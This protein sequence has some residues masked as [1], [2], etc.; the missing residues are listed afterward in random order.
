MDRIEHSQIVREK[1]GL[2]PV[3]QNP[4][5]PE[6]Q[7]ILD[8]FLFG[9]VWQQGGL[10]DVQRELITV[11]VLAAL[12]T[13]DQ[14]RSHVGA[15]LCVG[16]TPVQI[17]E[18]IYQCAPYIGFPRTLV[19]AQQA[20]Q[21]FEQRGISLPHPA[22][23]TVTEETR[24]QK[25]LEA[26]CAIFGQET[27]M[28]MRGSAPEDLK[29]IQDYLSAY[30]FGDIY[31][32]GGLGIPMRELLTFSVLCALGGCEGQVRAHIRG[33]LNVGNTRGTLIAALTQCLPYI[34][35]PRALNALSC[36]NEI[37]PAEK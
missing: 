33:N 3:S 16:A 35:F 5:D 24:L 21:V 17:K 6:L 2:A 37:V 34:G 15:A 10:E 23:A 22:Q 28:N 27:I 12:G 20:N 8:Y 32:R 31:T 9:E 4:A 7:K 29:H 25:G 18:A 36:I 13:P 14:C 19:A 26:Q 1:M 30:C 11:A